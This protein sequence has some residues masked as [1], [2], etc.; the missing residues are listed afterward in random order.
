MNEFGKEKTNFFWKLKGQ[1][2]ISHLCRTFVFKERSK[3][4]RKCGNTPSFL[5]PFRCQTFFW[6]IKPASQMR[7]TSLGNM[8][9]HISIYPFKEQ[10]LCWTYIVAL[11]FYAIKCGPTTFETGNDRCLVYEDE[12]WMVIWWSFFFQIYDTDLWSKEPS[13]GISI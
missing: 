1:I 2:G 13:F 4:T 11:F 6:K 5:K 10:L 9:E 12:F 3:N 8:F 7:F